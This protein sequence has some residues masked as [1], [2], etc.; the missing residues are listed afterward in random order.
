VITVDNAFSFRGR[1]VFISECDGVAPAE[2]SIYSTVAAP[3]RWDLEDTKAFLGSLVRQFQ[4]Y[5]FFVFDSRVVLRLHETDY[6]CMP[7]AIYIAR[8]GSTAPAKRSARGI[9]VRVSARGREMARVRKLLTT[10]A[11]KAQSAQKGTLLPSY[12]QARTN[13]QSVMR[14]RDRL[15]LTAWSR[16]QFLGHLTLA[17][18]SMTPLDTREMREIA[19]V[20]VLRRLRAR[21]VNDALL[22]AAH[23]RCKRKTLFG[24]IACEGTDRDLRLQRALSRDGWHELFVRHIITR[25]T[26]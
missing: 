25:V 5:R 23:A 2:T 8:S 9:T 1:Q 20:Y 15:T 24:H 13:A 4:P 14:A 6:D 11:Y 19:D 10:A 16:T 18:V 7:L 26:N 21:A 22:A 17:S 3:E 12:A